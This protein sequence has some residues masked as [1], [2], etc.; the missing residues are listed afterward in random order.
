MNYNI[1]IVRNPSS[2][3]FSLARFQGSCAYRD[4]YVRP[5]V[6]AFISAY[7]FLISAYS[8]FTCKSQKVKTGYLYSGTVR[9]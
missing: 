4:M 8:S 6:L 2:V 1:I 7:L 9:F 5:S 3:Q